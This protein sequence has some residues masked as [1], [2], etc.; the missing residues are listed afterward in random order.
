VIRASRWYVVRAHRHKEAM[1]RSHLQAR[2][3]EVFFPQLR[4]PSYVHASRRVIPL[5]PGYVFVRAAGAADFTAVS[6]TPGVRGLLGSPGTPAAIEDGVVEFFK[7][8]GT[9]DGVVFARSDLQPGQHVQITG[10]PFDGLAAI[11][12]RPPDGRGR[13]KVLMALLNRSVVRMRVPVQ[14]VRSGWV[15]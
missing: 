5:F 8:R 11:I 7:A 13:V 2:G 9:T 4:L 12:E 6:S 14:F 1:V 15:A 10:G 3:V